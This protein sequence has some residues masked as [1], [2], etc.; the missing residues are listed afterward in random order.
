MGGITLGVSWQGLVY[1]KDEGITS[2][3]LDVQPFFTAVCTDMDGCSGDEELLHWRIKKGGE[4]IQAEYSLFKLQIREM[5]QIAIKIIFEKKGNGARKER[6]YQIFAPSE[7][8]LREGETSIKLILAWKC[9]KICCCYV[10]EKLEA[11]YSLDK[12]HRARSVFPLQTKED[13]N[14]GI[15]KWLKETEASRE[16]MDQ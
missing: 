3:E 1:T 8:L 14:Q 10:S 7:G 6:S 5:Q 16:P 4:L 13:G 15:R 9:V 2:I 12:F 11:S